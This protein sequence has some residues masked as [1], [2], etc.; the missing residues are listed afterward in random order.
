MKNEKFLRGVGEIDDRILQRYDEIEKRMAAPKPNRSH[1]IRWGSVAACLCIIFT[2]VFLIQRRNDLNGGGSI[3]VVGDSEKITGAGTIGSS[4]KK[5]EAVTDGGSYPMPQFVFETYN[6]NEY[7]TFSKSPNL[8]FAL[9]SL[10]AFEIFGEF[11]YFYTWDGVK[12]ISDFDLTYL[13][14]FDQLST[15]IKINSRGSYSDY[16]KYF[17]DICIEDEDMP[18]NL[19]I[20]P[21]TYW[22]RNSENELVFEA[23]Y[24]KYN[25][26]SD[27]KCIHFKVNDNIV[28]RYLKLY[29]NPTVIFWYGDYVIELSFESGDGM[30][31][32]YDLICSNTII[33]SLL[34]K[35]TAPQAAE[36]LY[37]LWKDALK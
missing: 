14:Q 7:E 16:L 21:N 18:E 13:Y 2:S 28:L 34:T 12:T 4:E 8:P 26:S 5:T 35:S 20:N 36:A 24:Q 22:F 11:Y 29:D 27:D 3:D 23:Y 17:G 1:L 19:Y 15:R 31:N 6:A 25:I 33:K 9:F 30:D 32:G 10:D 37:N